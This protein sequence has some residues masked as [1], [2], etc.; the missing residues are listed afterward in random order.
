[1]GREK[2]FGLLASPAQGAVMRSR[3]QAQKSSHRHAAPAAGKVNKGDAS[4][5]CLL[6]ER[7]RL[8]QAQSGPAQYPS[9]LA[10]RR[11]PQHFS[12]RAQAAIWRDARGFSSKPDRER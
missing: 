4:R 8:Y 11:S 1:M 2:I 9:D 5:M 7:F 3:G 12:P 10:S 6:S